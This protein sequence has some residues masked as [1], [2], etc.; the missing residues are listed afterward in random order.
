MR[1]GNASIRDQIIEKLEAFFPIPPKPPKEETEI[2]MGFE[3][4]QQLDIR[5]RQLPIDEEW[6]KKFK[7]AIQ[8]N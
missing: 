7:L 3:D 5:Q 8:N 1:T 6:L 4:I 2:E